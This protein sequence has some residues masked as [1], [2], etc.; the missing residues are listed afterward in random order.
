MCAI[1]D[2]FVSQANQFCEHYYV[3][4]RANPFLHECVFVQVL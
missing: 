1:V 2:W 4:G 3:Y